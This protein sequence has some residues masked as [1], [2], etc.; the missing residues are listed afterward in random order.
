MKRIFSILALVTVLC[1]AV[2]GCSKTEPDPAVSPSAS[3]SVYEPAN[4]LKLLPDLEK[5]AELF[6][7]LDYVDHDH[8]H[9]DGSYYTQDI[10]TDG[11]TQVIA[12]GYANIREDGESEEDYALR[13]GLNMADYIYGEEGQNAE[14]T[15]N[16]TYTE[17][18]TYPVYIVRFQTGENEDT[19]LWTVYLTANDTYS[20]QYGFASKI[21]AV[22][23]DMEQRYTQ[24]FDS[25]DLL[26]NTDE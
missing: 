11:I 22:D 9:S 5:Q 17:K 14:V 20:F 16:E 2:T 13:R 24:V 18:L 21:D 1:F 4:K 7:E 26:E 19:I 3:D 25:I 15:L 10:T 12:S 8:P 23:D 6:G